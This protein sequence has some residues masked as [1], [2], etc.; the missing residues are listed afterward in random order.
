MTYQAYLDN[1][2][3]K[4]GKTPEDFKALAAQK[5]FMKPGVKAGEIVTWLKQDFGLGQGHAM[6][7]VLLLR[8]ASA[9]K[10]S[11]EEA[12]DK[13]FTGNRAHWRKPYDQLVRNVK[14]FGP[15]VA[16]APTNSYISLLR[17]G[18]KF[19]VVQVTSERMDVGIK[20][21]GAPAKGRLERSGTWNN[22]VT[23]RVRVDD[24]KQLNAEILSWLH[25]AYEQA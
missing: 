5:G 22:M 4:T 8:Q 20:L 21:K 17:S 2:Q 11:S 13:H 14:K 23:H 18:K 3:A 9:P 1:I 19:G 6:A 25:E 24:P 12:L 16:L 15:D 7:I 10:V